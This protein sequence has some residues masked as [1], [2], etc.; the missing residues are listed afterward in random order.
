[1]SGRGLGPVARAA[2][3]PEDARSDDPAYR[4]LDFAPIVQSDAAGLGDA[5]ARWRQRIAETVQSLELA[6]RAGDRCTGGAGGSAIERPRGPISA[7]ASAET[8]TGVLL[9]VLPVLLAGLEWGDAVTTIVSL[10]LDLRESAVG[11]TPLAPT[12]V[13][14]PSGG[15]GGM[16]GMEKK[17]N[18]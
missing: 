11:A 3:V 9:S 7:S 2:G 4:A 18:A 6:G 5:R 16:S 8:P 15:M 12:L 1:M 14:E 10:D 17:G 13:V